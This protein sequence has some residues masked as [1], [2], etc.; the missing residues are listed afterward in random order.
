MLARRR[1]CQPT[2]PSL[3]GT[4]LARLCPDGVVRTQ[5][6][7]R[8]LCILIGAL[9]LAIGCSERFESHFDTASEARAALAERGWWPEQIP[10]GVSSISEAH[11]LDTNDQKILFSV[12]TKQCSEIAKRAESSGDDLPRVPR[13]RLADWPTW[14]RG[15][16]TKAELAAR[17]GTVLTAT[18][19]V[20]AL[21]CDDGKGY[22]WRDPR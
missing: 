12:D 1:S 5:C 14:L 11:D 17:K 21:F 10:A 15:T 13:L 6:H 3:P 20:L 7:C 8:I 16:V 19:G 9:I 2:R 22:F 18:G 4:L